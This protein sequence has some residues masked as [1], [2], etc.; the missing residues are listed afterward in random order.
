[1]YHASTLMGAIL[2]RQGAIHVAPREL[3]SKGG[4]TEVSGGP[5][6]IACLAVH[7][8]S[9]RGHGR[10]MEGEENGDCWTLAYNDKIHGV[11]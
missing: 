4:C 7:S 10:G 6:L 9:S 3:S 1:M 5:G 2:V 11:L 8:V